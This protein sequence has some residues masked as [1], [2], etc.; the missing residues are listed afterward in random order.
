VPSGRRQLYI[1]RSSA[2][3]R[4][5]GWAIFDEEQL[6]LFEEFRAGYTV[7]QQHSFL[8]APSPDDGSQ[9]HYSAA[10][11]NPR[12]DVAASTVGPACPATSGL[13]R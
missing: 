11:F 4:R 9:R 13:A 2:R 7:A 5:S 3:L 1:Q 6:F 8:G 10:C 12:P